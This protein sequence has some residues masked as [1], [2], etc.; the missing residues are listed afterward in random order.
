MTLPLPLL[1]LF[2]LVFLLG[3]LPLVSV[4]QLRVVDGLEIERVP[5]YL[6]SVGTLVVLGAGAWLVGAR[7]DGAA[8]LGL[9][10]ADFG[11]VAAWTT[12]L[13]VTGLALVVVYRQVGIVLGARESALLR[14]LM[15]RTAKERGVFA[16]LSV[17]AGV[18]EELAYRGF[19]LTTLAVLTGTG[20]AVLATSVVFGVL[21]AYQG[22][23]GVVRT[24]S[25]GGVL[26]V[27]FVA[28]GSL[29]AP[30]A[31]HVILD[32]ILGIVLADRLMVPEGTI[33][34]PGAVNEGT[35][36]PRE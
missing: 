23:L 1:D 17:A 5:A 20:W 28:S 30:M 10:A 33:G 36:S 14:T 29:W 2:A 12:A 13:V 15:P 4:A 31:A 27:G 3:G 18:C 26:A 6:S 25:L 7:K 22:W 21:H 8:A 34:V 9:G 24:A 19:A 11:V 16:V 35:A 32:L